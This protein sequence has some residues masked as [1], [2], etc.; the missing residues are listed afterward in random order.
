M[1]KN[2]KAMDEVLKRLFT[3]RAFRE[4]LRRDPETALAPYRLTPPQRQRLSRLCK[5]P[6]QRAAASPVRVRPPMDNPFSLN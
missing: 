6:P 4:R 1:D 3:D 2:L 5:Q